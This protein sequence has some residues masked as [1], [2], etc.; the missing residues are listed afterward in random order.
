[1][2]WWGDYAIHIANGYFS[3]KLYNQPNWPDLHCYINQLVI[4]PEGKPVEQQIIA[5]LELVRTEQV[6]SIRLGGAN[7][8]DMPIIDPH[9]LEDPLDIQRMVEGWIKHL[10]L[11]S[12]LSY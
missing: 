5:E 12:F 11:D 3:S 4:A 6:G 9:F 1:M 7:P 2:R 10:L 8:E